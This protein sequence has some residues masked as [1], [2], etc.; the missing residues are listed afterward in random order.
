MKFVLIALTFIQSLAVSAHA[1]QQ[2]SQAICASFQAKVD[3]ECA[4]IMCDDDIANGTYKN[5]DD[6][7]RAS[8]YA[9]AAQ[10][11]CDS[12]PTS[13]EGLVKQYNH[14]HPNAKIKCE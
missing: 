9:E 12:Q 6:C 2:S 11:G 14:A 5:L 3:E 8:D 13:V 1:G 10:G 4:H 7:T